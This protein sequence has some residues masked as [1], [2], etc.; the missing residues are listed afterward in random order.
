MLSGILHASCWE[1]N[2]FWCILKE[3]LLNIFPCWKAH[4]FKD[5][6]LHRKLDTFKATQQILCTEVILLYHLRNVKD[7]HWTEALYTSPA[8]CRIL[9]AGSSSL[10][11][12]LSQHKAGTPWV[13]VPSQIRYIM[14]L[15]L[16]FKCHHENHAASAPPHGCSNKERF[17]RNSSK[18]QHFDS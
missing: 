4:I 17:I 9:L 10:Q 11:R 14:K 12:L 16:G 18:L 8:A 13:S 3:Q 2:R 1:N 15:I 6:K 7:A 5:E